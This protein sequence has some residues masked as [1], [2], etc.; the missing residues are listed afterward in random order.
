[1]RV[2]GIREVRVRLIAI[3]Q[4]F[5]D[6]EIDLEMSLRVETEARLENGKRE[7]QR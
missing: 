5:F 4:L 3:K 6:L 2:R 1:V 7:T